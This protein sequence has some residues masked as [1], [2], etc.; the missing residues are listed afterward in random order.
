[1]CAFPSM[2]AQNTLLLQ[3]GTTEY[4]ICIYHAPQSFLPQPNMPMLAC[5]SGR[6]AAKLPARASDSL[7]DTDGLGGSCAVA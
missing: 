2:L 5:C 1:M 4:C 3:H 7:R 6:S